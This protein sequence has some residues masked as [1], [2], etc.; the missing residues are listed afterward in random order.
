MKKLKNAM[1]DGSRNGFGPSAGP[2][3][4]NLPRYISALLLAA[5]F[6]VELGIAGFII[7]DLRIA[8]DEAHRMYAE[9]VLGL[10]RIGELQ[11]DAQE[12]RR[13]TLY[14]LTTNDSN[15]QIEY[16]DQS[17]GADR[18]VRE[19]ISQYLHEARTQEEMALGRRLISDWTAYLKIRDEVL[20]S[21]LEG[22]IKDAVSLDLSGGVSSFD[23]VGQ[24][25]EEIKRHYDQRASERLANVAASSRRTLTRLISVLAFTLIFASASVWAIQR[26]RMLGTLQ[27]AKM[28]MDFVASVSHE[29]RTP[30]AVISSAADN[31]TDGLVAG[32]DQVQ[33]YGAIIGKQSRQMTDLVNQILLFASTRDGQGRYIPQ[34]IPVDEVIRSV[35]DNTAD[36]TREAGF[37]IEQN[38]EAGLPLVKADPAALSK[39]LQNL[40]INAVKYSGNSRWIG[41]TAWLARSHDRNHREVRIS[42]RDRGIGIA[43]SEIERIFEPFYRSPRVGAAQIH[44]TGLGLP[45]AKSMVEGMGGRISV[46]SKLGIG[47]VFTIHLP[48]PEGGEARH[49]LLTSRI[50]PFS[51]T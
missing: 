47:S 31:I 5:V 41:M 12:T 3:V 29:L 25:L 32:K 27:L 42:I 1:R 23:R 11:Y 26:N 6:F 48:I 17:R 8:D 13:S 49:E 2:F 30:L 16:A 7:R 24:D 19:A 18:R 4:S 46:E 36:L 28:Q 37:E 39:A 43:P 22:S 9:S 38:V 21:I 50:H 33:R 40:L 10:R 20:A 45:L 35:V 15:L 14:A 44:G 51:R 34:P